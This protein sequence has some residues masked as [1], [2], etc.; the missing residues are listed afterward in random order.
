MNAI[1]AERYDKTPLPRHLGVYARS[2]AYPAFNG[3]IPGKER[4]RA[5]PAKTPFSYYEYVIFLR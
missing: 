1:L 3:N 2:A 4:L 5:W